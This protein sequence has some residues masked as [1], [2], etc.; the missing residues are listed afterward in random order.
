MTKRRP[1]RSNLGPDRYLRAGPETPPAPPRSD[2]LAPS[3]VESRRHLCEVLDALAD[4]RDGLV[5]IGSH[6]V[7]ERTK[8]LAVGST[9]T[10]DSDLAVIPSLVSAEP[11]LEQVMRAAGFRPLGEFTEHPSYTRYEQEPGLWGKGFGPD[12]R[13]VAEVDFIVPDALAD[14]QDQTGSPASMATHGPKTT[15][16]APGIELAAADRDLLPISSFDDY[17][18]REVWVAGCT[19]LL[20]A[21]AF[22]LGERVEQRNTTGRN[23]VRPKDGGDIWRLMAASDPT[24]VATTFVRL[25]GD[26]VV[27]PVAHAGLAH[28]SDLIRSGDLR[29]LAIQELS[30]KLGDDEEV[31]AV[32]FEWT[33]TFLRAKAERESLT[34]LAVEL[35]D[36]H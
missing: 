2:G 29:E 21:K 4:H 15:R 28:L 35:D 32:Y 11:N 33:H 7:H 24:S 14:G 27:G 17:S 6:A 5:V 3:L 30:D 13:P 16:T 34:G 18:T 12:G 31:E 22:K 26:K 8:H 19:A 23:R 36:D 20:C 1:V 25:T 10:K 9:A